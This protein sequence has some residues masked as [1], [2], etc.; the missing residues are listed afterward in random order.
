MFRVL[1]LAGFVAVSCA[2]VS[3]SEL[4]RAKTVAYGK[5]QFAANPFGFELTVENLMRHY[6]KS[7]K[8]DHYLM[9]QPDEI[10]RFFKGKTE[11]MFLQPYRE[12]MKVVS[13][14]IY[15][16]AV[17]LYNGICTGMSRK[18][19]FWKFSDWTYD[20]ADTLTIHSPATGCMFKFVFVKDKLKSI[21]ITNI[22]LRFEKSKLISEYE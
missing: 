6:G 5:E 4:K 12:E 20:S 18:E 22:V 10:Y 8:M 13:G 16:S 15:S 11:I 14:D 1:L 9:Q 7:L 21:H 17:K 3:N 19:F 2:G